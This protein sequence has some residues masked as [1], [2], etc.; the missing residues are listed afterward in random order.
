MNDA[1]KNAYAHIKTLSSERDALR[2]QV[3][4]LEGE[5]AQARLDMEE[6]VCQFRTEQD[7]HE[8][9]QRQETRVIERLK[10]ATKLIEVQAQTH[11]QHQC[12]CPLCNFIFE[13]QAIDAARTAP[14]NGAASRTDRSSET[15][16]A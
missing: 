1:L 4:R 6:A 5:L 3:E 8:F 15:D 10:V 9:T 14:E 12:N 16:P 11:M 7:L 13:Q 2:S